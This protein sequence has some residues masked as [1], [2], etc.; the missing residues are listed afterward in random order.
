MHVCE[1]HF[2]AVIGYQN[3]ELGFLMKK[4]VSYSQYVY[5][6]IDFTTCIY[7]TS[8]LKT[9]HFATHEGSAPGKI[10]ES[11]EDSTIKLGV[12]SSIC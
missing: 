5:N 11:P 6:K 7:V 2:A 9:S 3:F 1:S 12:Y 4:T 8:N 10:I